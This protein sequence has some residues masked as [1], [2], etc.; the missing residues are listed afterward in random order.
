LAPTARDDLFGEDSEDY[1]GKT[2]RIN[3]IDFKVVGLTESKGSS[4]S[5]NDDDKIYIPIKLRKNF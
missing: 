3:S 5:S 1:L 2:I 4:G